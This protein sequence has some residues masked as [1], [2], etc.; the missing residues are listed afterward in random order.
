MS[1]CNILLNLLII[2]LYIGAKTAVLSFFMFQAYREPPPEFD[3]VAYFSFENIRKDLGKVRLLWCIT[4]K[5]IELAVVMDSVV[6]LQL[7]LESD[8][9][10]AASVHVFGV[11]APHLSTD[12]EQLRLNTFLLDLHE[13]SICTGITAG[14][15]QNVA[16][17][18]DGSSSKQYY[19]H[20][21]NLAANVMF[22]NKSCIISNSCQL[23]LPTIQDSHNMFIN[24]SHVEHTLTARYQRQEQKSLQHDIKSNDYMV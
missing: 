4:E 7:T 17:L 12:L 22:F 24:C 21:I 11:P 5:T 3:R 8:T 15:L 10:M 19:R 13:R 16:S 6:K 9:Y 1:I 14:V 23:L 2:I 20:I 18:A